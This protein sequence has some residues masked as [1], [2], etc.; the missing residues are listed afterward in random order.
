MATQQ[1]NTSA[2]DRPSL[3]PKTTLVIAILSG[4][5]PEVIQ[6]KPEKVRAICHLEPPRQEKYAPE[7]PRKTLTI[8]IET[9]RFQCRKCRKQG[10]AAEML[11]IT[12]K[13]SIED[14]LTL[15]PNDLKQLTLQRPIPDRENLPPPRQVHD[16]PII[17]QYTPTLTAAYQYYRRNMNRQ[18]PYEY[19]YQL[20]V[21]VRRAVIAGI[22]YGRRSGES[23]L[24]DHLHERDLTNAEIE[25]SHLMVGPGN[26]FDRFT[27]HLTI[28][29]KDRSGAIIWYAATR[30]TAPTDDQPWRERPPEVRTLPGSRPFMVGVTNTPENPSTLVVTDDIRLFIVT[31]CYQDEAPVWLND[32]R[33]AADAPRFAELIRQTNPAHMVM[34]FHN[35]ETRDALMDTVADDENATTSQIM[36]TNAM[37]RFI[38][39]RRFGRDWSFL[40]SNT[41]NSIRR[42]IRTDH[43]RESMGHPTRM[44]PPPRQRPQGPIQI[45]VLDRPERQSRTERAMQSMEEIA[46]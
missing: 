37:M 35:A 13:T 18:Q 41:M 14:A 30:A 24:R 11:A 44:T 38:D 7:Q 21:N 15:A 20:G 26:R 29:E 12:W 9:G 36:T 16:A 43:Q 39:S 1:K 40:G 10:G 5:Q 22:G 46:E 8:D 23:P 34:A 4:G 42:Q 2:T 32:R 28:A 3:D 17:R 45:K 6:G 19:L 27:G 25:S 33:T 31:R